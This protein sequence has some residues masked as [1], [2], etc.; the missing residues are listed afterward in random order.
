MYRTG[1]W[2]K[3]IDCAHPCKNTID[4]PYGCK[5]R[6]NV[7]T[8]LSKDN[9][10]TYLLKVCAFSTPEKAVYCYTW[11]IGCFESGILIDR[12]NW[13]WKWGGRT[14]RS[15]HEKLQRH[16][17]IYVE[18]TNLLVLYNHLINTKWSMLHNFH[19]FWIIISP[20]A[21]SGIQIILLICLHTKEW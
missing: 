16:V 3:I 13:H 9:N 6:R 14:E 10:K 11:A 15:I 4:H 19:P 17:F 18:Q 21:H 12:A 7:A 1:I 8:N 5:T 2:F 20:I